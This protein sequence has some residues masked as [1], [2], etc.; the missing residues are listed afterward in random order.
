LLIGLPVA[1]LCLAAGGR[2]AGRFQSMPVYLA[3]P[4]T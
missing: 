1:E 4:A 2:Q 3:A